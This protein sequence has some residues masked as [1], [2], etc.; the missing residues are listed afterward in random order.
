MVEITIAMI[1][2]MAI[3]IVETIRVT[4]SKMTKLSDATNMAE[5]TRTEISSAT[6][7][8]VAPTSTAMKQVRNFSASEEEERSEEN[9]IDII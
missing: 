7:I 5:T 4:P 6:T 8:S 9:R 1:K 3:L 2:M